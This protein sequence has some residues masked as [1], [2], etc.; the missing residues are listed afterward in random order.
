MKETILDEIMMLR[1]GKACGKIDYGGEYVVSVSETD[2]TKTLYAFSVP[3]FRGKTRQL[4]CRSFAKKGEDHYL[5]GAAANIVAGK[6]ICL[7]NEDGYCRIDLRKRV[8]SVTEDYITYEDATVFPTLNGVAVK[9]NRKAGVPFE[10]SLRLSQSFLQCR[11]N[12]GSFSLMQREFQPFVTISCI[13]AF[14]PD[15]RNLAPC[16]LQSYRIGDGEYQL[17]VRHDAADARA[18]LFEANLYTEKLFSDTTVESRN[19]GKNNVF[20]GAAFLG[21]TELCGEQ[22]L[23]SRPDF[24]KVPEVYDKRICRAVFHMPIFCTAVPLTAYR[25]PSRFC[26]FGSSWNNKVLPGKAAAKAVLN[27]NYLSFDIRNCIVDKDGFLQPFEGLVIKPV[28]KRTEPAAVATAD[29]YFAPQI[30]ELN[31]R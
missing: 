29:S 28:Q 26:S 15:G 4:V 24:S 10:F 8:H 19:P 20:G 16:W 5:Q 31:I 22:W 18:L 14:H 12:N 23:Y 11:E 3:V 21:N 27:G 9:V 25:L 7:K 30:L 6:K 2:G 13:G 17:I 1:R